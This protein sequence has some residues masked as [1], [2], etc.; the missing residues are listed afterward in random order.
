METNGALPMPHDLGY[1]IDE[2]NEESIFIFNVAESVYK[3]A[4]WV[5]FGVEEGRGED[6]LARDQN[7]HERGR[8]VKA[9]I[10]MRS[11]MRLGLLVFVSAILAVLVPEQ[12]SAAAIMP[13][14]QRAVGTLPLLAALGV[15]IVIAA[16]AVVAFLQMTAQGKHAGETAD[17]VQEEPLHAVDEDDDSDA[18]YFA[19][20]P[21]VMPHSAT[22]GQE[23]IEPSLQDHTVPLGQTQIVSSTPIMESARGPRLRGIGGEFAG[24][25]FKVTD[26]G[27]SIGRDPAY[28]H[29]VFPPSA[30]EVSRRHCT[31]RYE[32]DS[33]LFYLEDHGSSNGTFLSDGRQLEPGKWYPLRPGE[34]F[35]LSGEIHWFTVQDES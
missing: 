11:R 32:A 10:C 21:S 6:V 26:S 20:H 27:L 8:R 7:N 33:Q 18:V 34:R 30:N 1:T 29:I 2:R 25:V 9:A 22:D 28:C 23:A 19:E 13:A 35:A 31:L 15:G 12:T 16:G 4:V 17:W 14:A 5:R 3:M 24:L